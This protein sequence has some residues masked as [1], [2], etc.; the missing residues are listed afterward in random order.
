MRKAER[1]EAQEEEEAETEHTLT[2]L[3]NSKT[4]GEDGKLAE[5]DKAMGKLNDWNLTYEQ[6]KISDEWHYGVIWLA[7][8]RKENETNYEKYI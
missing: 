5:I 2:K 7:Y 3:K 6:E 4:A 8:K 1:Q